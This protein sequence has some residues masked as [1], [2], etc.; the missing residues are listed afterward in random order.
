MISGFYR[1]GM[2]FTKRNNIMESIFRNHYSSNIVHSIASQ[3]LD[4]SSSIFKT[5]PKPRKRLKLNGFCRHEFHKGCIDP[6][7]LE[8]R[9]CPMCKMNILKHYG[10]TSSISRESV[11]PTDL[12]GGTSE[13]NNMSEVRNGYYC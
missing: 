1:A 10:F 12:E 2:P 11:F 13:Q 4:L 9:T 6:W 8:H 7:L 3:N 5:G